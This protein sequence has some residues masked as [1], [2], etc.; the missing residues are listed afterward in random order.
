MIDND[1]VNYLSNKYL[2][3]KKISFIRKNPNGGY[4][5]LSEKGKHLGTYPSRSQAEKRLKQIEFFKYKK[6]K[7]NKKAAAAECLDLSH[8]DDLS[9]SAVMREI[10]QQCSDETMKD[11][12]SIFKAIFD[13]LL[14]LGNND[15][16]DATMPIA[17][18]MFN[19]LHEINL[20]D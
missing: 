11:F 1:F 20:N 13:G 7:R 10:K 4:S 3:I 19:K 16:A 9:F 17:L 12:L 2:D 6:K 18:F 15:P 14:L 8:L 5:I